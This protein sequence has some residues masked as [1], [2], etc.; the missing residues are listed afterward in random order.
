MHL[1][2]GIGYRWYYNM[3]A[4]EGFVKDWLD[5]VRDWMV[6]QPSSLYISPLT[7]FPTQAKILSRV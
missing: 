5:W 6:M 2:I 4:C 3:E 7:I 1:I